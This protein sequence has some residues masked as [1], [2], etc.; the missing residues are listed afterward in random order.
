[1]LVYRIPLQPKRHC[2]QRIRQI[3]VPLDTRQINQ[4]RKDRFPP[5]GKPSKVVRLNRSDYNNYPVLRHRLIEMNFLME[6]I[7]SQQLHR[8]RIGR[9]MPAY[10][11]ANGRKMFA[12]DAFELG[13]GRW[14]MRARGNDEISP[15]QNS[16]DDSFDPFQ[17]QARR[18]MAVGVINDKQ[19]PVSLEK[20]RAVGFY[21]FSLKLL[22]R[23]RVGD[24][25]GDKFVE[26]DVRRNRQRE[27]IRSVH[28][29]DFS[30]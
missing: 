22:E 14:F 8:C 11:P 25:R 3:M 30:L 23:N 5:A 20:S 18:S 6:D 9:H 17:N 29:S 16:R 12:E 27:M 15:R 7:L 21:K 24:A 26:L 1:M 10:P 4:P 28:Q 19:K 13:L 2:F